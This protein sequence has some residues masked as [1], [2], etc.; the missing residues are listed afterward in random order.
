[1]NAAGSMLLSVAVRSVGAGTQG[2]LIPRLD[3]I[4]TDARLRRGPGPFGDPSQSPL[5]RVLPSA[6]FGSAKEKYSSARSP[7]FLPSWDGVSAMAVGRSSTKFRSHLL[8][9]SPRRA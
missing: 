8:S 4:G 7:A 9:K 5:K 6:R 1:M 2:G 3:S